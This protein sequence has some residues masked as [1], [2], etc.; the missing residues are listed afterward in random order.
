MTLWVGDKPLILASQSKSRQALLQ[1]AG[2]RVDD[3]CFSLSAR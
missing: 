2:I 3:G 1:A